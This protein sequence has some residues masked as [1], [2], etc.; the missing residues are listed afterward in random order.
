MLA[1]EIISYSFEKTKFKIGDNCWYTPDYVV[2]M[3]GH[4]EIHEVKG[5]LIRDDAMVKFKAAAELFP[6]YR[7]VMAQYKG[8]KW[9]VIR[10]I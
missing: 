6:Y 3:P 9:E 10:E 5:G 7:F 8:K 1:G 4:F 2:V